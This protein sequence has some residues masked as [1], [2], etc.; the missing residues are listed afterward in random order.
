[1]FLQGVS[2]HWTLRNVAK[3]QAPFKRNQALSGVQFMFIKGL[4]SFLVSSVVKHPVVACLP[5]ALPCLR[6]QST[7]VQEWGDTEQVH[8]PSLPH[9]TTWSTCPPGGPRHLPGHVRWPQRGAEGDPRPGHQVTWKKEIYTLLKILKFKNS[10]KS[11]DF[12]ASHFMCW[13]I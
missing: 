9:L 5:R 12:K 6:L 13:W 7:E 10:R 1:M 11:V 8:L 3:S 2:R 4:A